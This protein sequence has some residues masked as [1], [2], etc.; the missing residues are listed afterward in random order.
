M[1]PDWSS[2]APGEKA[3]RDKVKPV[4][5]VDVLKHSHSGWESEGKLSGEFTKSKQNKLLKLQEELGQ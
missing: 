3:W 5:D 1:N 4:I 2:R